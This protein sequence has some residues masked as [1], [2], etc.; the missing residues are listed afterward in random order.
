MISTMDL[1]VEVE[2]RKFNK[3][4]MDLPLLMDNNSEQE[5]LFQ[6]AKQFPAIQ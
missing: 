4:K 5:K 2:K 6:S 3:T 1:P